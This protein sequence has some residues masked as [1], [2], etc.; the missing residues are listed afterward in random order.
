MPRKTVYLVTGAGRGIGLGLVTALAARA[1]TVVF[2]G[3]RNPETQ[4]LKAL[5][6]AHPNLHPVKLTAGDQ[7]DNEA[8][9]AEIQ[10]IAGQLDVIIACAGIARQGFLASTPISEFREH[11]EVNTIG[12][13]MLFQIAKDLLLASPRPEGPIFALISSI[14]GSIAMYHP[15]EHPSLIAMAIHPGWVQ[16]DMGNPG[17]AQAGLEKAPVTVGES[18]EGILSRVDGATKEK[19][20][21]KFWNFK[22]SSG[23]PL[24][25]ATEEIPW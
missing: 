6:A 20:S 25:I 3:A 24:D 11:Y 2:A 15:I 9:I 4:A 23:K 12:P 1:D 5:A 14:S 22:A 8:A 7:A 10:K 19:S 17:A 16:T 21:A 13:V 18:V